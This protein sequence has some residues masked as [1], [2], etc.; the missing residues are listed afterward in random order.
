MIP[1]RNI[2]RTAITAMA[3]ASISIERAC[4]LLRPGDPYADP[5]FIP[6]ALRIPGESA[7]LATQPAVATDPSFLG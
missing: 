3:V 6:G 4:S 1:Y 5:E 2:R 7:L